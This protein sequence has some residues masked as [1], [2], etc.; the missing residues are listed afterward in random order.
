MKLIDDDGCQRDFYFEMS[1]YSCH[2]WRSH[3]E[4]HLAIYELYKRT[5]ELPGSVIEFGVYNGST[6]FFLA[7]LI[8]IFNG[9]QSEK[10]ASTSHHLYGF[11]TFEGILRLSEH[12]KSASGSSVSVNKAGGFAQDWEIF[13]K[14]FDRFISST[15]I[16]QRI[17]LIKG[18]VCDTFPAFLKEEP[19]VRFRLVL[20][21]VDLFEPTKVVLDRIMDRMVPGGIIIFDEYGFS[22][23][24]GESVAVDP[25]I[26]KYGLKLRSMPWTYAPGAYTVS[27]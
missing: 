19:G 27:E 12:D 23:W 21:D 2:L 18:D 10:Y 3:L 14:D 24:P 5:I 11:D 8:E 25:F 16:G 7:R 4:R 9:A 17:H 6:F 26:K 1:K 20:L 15:P 22:E 13:K